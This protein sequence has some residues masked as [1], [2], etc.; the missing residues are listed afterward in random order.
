M[1]DYLPVVP[2]ELDEHDGRGELQPVGRL[3]ELS[4]GLRQAMVV[5]RPGAESGRVFEMVD[6][7][8]FRVDG[9]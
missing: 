1:Q 2:G 5:L 3:E 6:L 7:V 4:G 8:S 9:V